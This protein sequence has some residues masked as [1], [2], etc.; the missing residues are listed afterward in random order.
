MKRKRGHEI[1]F[2]DKQLIGRRLAK[3]G[4]LR[5]FYSVSFVIFECSPEGERILID[6]I[7]A[8]LED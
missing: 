2:D 8:S 3:S 6:R 5:G 4:Y 7:L 1:L